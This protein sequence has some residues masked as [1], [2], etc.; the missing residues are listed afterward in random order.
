MATLATITVSYNG[1]MLAFKLEIPPEAH[2]YGVS[3]YSTTRRHIV[4]NGD[5]TEH[6]AAIIEKNLDSLAENL[7]RELHG[8][9]DTIP[10][11]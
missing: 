5:I 11:F 6:G 8:A 10:M 7:F 2:A 4:P 3:G 9:W 1:R